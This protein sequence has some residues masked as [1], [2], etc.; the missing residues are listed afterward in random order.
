[1][2]SDYT[3]VTETWGLPASPEQLAMQ[4]FR[5][6]L[7]AEVGHGGAVL[8]V[9][10]GSGMGLPYLQNH[11]RMSVGGD[12]TLR[13]LR[14]GRRHIPQA[15]LVC[16]D[17]QR[18]PFLDATF[19][20]V[21]ML[22]MIYYLPDHE[23]AIAECRRVLKPGGSL[24]VCLPN[25]DRP[26]FNPSPLSTRY[27]NTSEIDSLLD[28]CGFDVRVYGA[29]P[30]E[31]TTPRDRALAPLRH[32]AVRF[33]L[34]PRSMR[35]KALVKRVLYGKLPELGAVHDGMAAYSEPVQL[36]PSAGPNREFKNLYA[37]G[38]RP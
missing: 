17:A 20:A 11:S 18:L 34:I 32:F 7:A 15:N 19:D 3:A 13:L 16:M 38:T 9:G 31:E 25:R 14:E 22:E 23:A 1:M 21:L 24:M 36:D 28:G 30:A 5:Y 10:C 8:E 6:R 29:F 27:F 33:H 35:A 26:D 37:I 4:Y 2:T 12:Y